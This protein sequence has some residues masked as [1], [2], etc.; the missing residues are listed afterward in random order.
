MSQENVDAVR[1]VY[2]AFAKGDVPFV[3]GLF[4]PEIEWNEAEN[5]IYADRNPYVG[6]EAVL[7]GV[8]MRLG[9]EWD[10]FSAEP[11]EFLDAGEKAVA[12]GTYVGAYKATGKPVRAQ[13]AHVWTLRG[14][15]VI[16]FQQYTD[17]AQF[18]RAVSD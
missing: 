6:P 1:G 7:G 9:T 11:Q 10:G 12:L 14:G 16:G 8:F 4:D 5:Y 15:K 18:A 2:E 13:F 3:L 17:T